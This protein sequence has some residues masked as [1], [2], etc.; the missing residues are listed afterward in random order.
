MSRV[1][2]SP[3]PSTRLIDEISPMVCGSTPRSFTEREMGLQRRDTSRCRRHSAHLEAADKATLLAP[4]S[5]RLAFVTS[6]SVLAEALGPHC[7]TLAYLD[8][9]FIICTDSTP[10]SDAFA[11]FNTRTSSIQLNKAKRECVSLVEKSGR[12]VESCSGLVWPPF[13]RRTFLS[14]K[15]ARRRTEAR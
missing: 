12:R 2:T 10:L 5:S 6:L 8:N 13:W 7:R 15:V 1:S 4:S 14:A 9:F 3:T 11:F